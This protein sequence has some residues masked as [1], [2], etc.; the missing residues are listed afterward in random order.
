MLATRHRRTAF[1]LL[2]VL[3]VMVVILILGG[4]LM[5]TLL[6]MWSNNR[7]KAGA[8]LLTARLADARGLAVAQGRPFL[9]QYS[10]DLRQ[11]R[12]TLDE[13]D[14]T[15]QPADDSNRIVLGGSQELPVGVVLTPIVASTLSPA[16]T[17]G[18]VTLVVY[19]PD[20]TCPES[21]EVEVGEPEHLDVPTITVRVRGLTGVVT[22][23]PTAAIPAG[24]RP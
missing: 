6:G 14:Q 3:L 11:V 15:E 13:S 16:P 10:A 4:V 8:D 5:P 24:S 20:G 21:M 22:A 18:W 17:D 9:V 7:T 1:T 19:Q 12:V 23:N 2:E